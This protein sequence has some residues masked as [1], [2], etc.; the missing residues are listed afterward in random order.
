M[1]KTWQSSALGVLIGCIGLSPGCATPPPCTPA[2]AV[3]VSAAQARDTI[4]EA[5]QVV[6][7]TPPTVSS[8]TVALE[9][10]VTMQEKRIAELSAQLRLLKRIDLERR[11][12]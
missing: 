3:Q 4:S 7:Q 8:V 12:Q 6:P 1:W 2:G 5:A 9:R 11:T 10:K